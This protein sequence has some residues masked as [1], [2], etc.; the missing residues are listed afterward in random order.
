MQRS[1][2]DR[3]LCVFSGVLLL[4]VRKTP[5]CCTV[6]STGSMTVAHPSKYFTSTPKKLIQLE[7][8][9]FCC[10]VMVCDRHA[11]FFVV[12]SMAMAKNVTT[13]AILIIPI[14]YGHPFIV[15][16]GYLD[17]DTEDTTLKR[18]LDR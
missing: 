13:S 4:F 15:L 18:I 7:L 9:L 6:T 16:Y 5:L 12:I 2:R 3:H 14:R 10:E 8:M 11:V 1:L 17:K